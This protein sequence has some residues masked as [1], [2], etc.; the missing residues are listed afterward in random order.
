MESKA[1][2]VVKGF[3]KHESRD[4]VLD[5]LRAR[6]FDLTSDQEAHYNDLVAHLGQVFSAFTEMVPKLAEAFP[7]HT[8]IVRPHPSENHDRWREVVADVAN[9]DVIYEGSVEPWMLGSDVVIH[10]A[11]TTGIGAYSLDHPVISYMPVVHPVFNRLSHL[12][13]LL[14]ERPT[15]VD[16]VIATVRQIQAGKKISREREK[17]KKH[18]ASSTIANAFSPTSCECI[19][20]ALLE[21]QERASAERSTNESLRG[22]RLRFAIRNIAA[23]TRRSLRKA[24]PIDTYM[25]QK[26]PGLTIGEIQSVLQKLSDARGQGPVP[27]VQPHPKLPSCFLITAA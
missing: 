6:G 21:L 22:S 10:N 17:E 7:E 25:D 20:E 2:F 1:E 15:T 4:N 14:S 27:A 11:S 13:N 18:A 23:T 8:I 3:N 5:V 19:A 12:P 9:A 24:S 26:F 16:D